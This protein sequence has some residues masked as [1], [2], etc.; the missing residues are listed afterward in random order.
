MGRGVVIDVRVPPGPIGAGEARRALRSIEPKLPPARYAAIRL[1]VSQL[2]A[3]ARWHPSVATT[4][5]LGLKVERDP[6]VVR[7]EVTDIVPERSGQ[8]QR[9]AASW[10]LFLLEEL[11]D[12]WGILT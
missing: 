4:S 9:E 1:L 8:D 6:G 3:D 10:D 5:S 7:V 12:R 2:I 11:S